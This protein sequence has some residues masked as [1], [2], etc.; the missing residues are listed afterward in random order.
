MT[1]TSS[2]RRVRVFLVALVTTLLVFGG[3]AL[4]AGATELTGDET[5]MDSTSS[6]STETMPT[7]EPTP[8][9]EPEVVTPPAP[10]A[11]P[12]PPPPA[13][14][15]AP[16]PG[17]PPPGNLPLPPLP[18][19]ANHPDVIV[20]PAWLDKPETAALDPEARRGAGAVVWV[21]RVL[22]DPTPRAKRLAP[23]FARTLRSV[24]RRERVHW[25][26]VLGVLRAS[27]HEGRVP[28]T[29]RQMT[30]LAHHLRKAGVRRNARAGLA[31]Y[32]G[33][34]F[35]ERALAL[36]HYNRAVR[37]RALVRGLA[38]SKAGFQRRILA[39]R[40]IELYSL[41]RA[42]VASG[43]I[44][45]RVLV[46]LLYLADTYHEVTVSSLQTGHRLFARPGVVS[47]HIHGLAV[48]I[49]ALGNVSIAG[50]QR[51]GGVTEHAVRAIL[52]LPAELQP[53]QVISLLGLG[54]ASFPLADHGDHIHVGF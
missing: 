44:D 50:N 13:E 27:G 4:A 51:P 37:L 43:R 10:P 8:V 15:P 48:D 16:D 39:S 6:E 42:D 5:L 20:P 36:G 53:R 26:L 40:R 38:A 17:A 33:A 24:A 21:Y 19:P 11:P 25:S 31:A 35:A 1:K 12:P 29:K 54:G 32:S 46:L 14:E 49:T 34:A 45:V 22:P 52:L 2:T 30:S 18:E 28:A 9:P 41:G 7:P 47:A 3:A 23:A